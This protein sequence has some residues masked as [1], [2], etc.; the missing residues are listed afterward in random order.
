MKWLRTIA[1]T[2]IRDLDRHFD[3]TQHKRYSEEFYLFM[4]SSQKPLQAL[5]KLSQRFSW[6]S[7]QSSYGSNSLEYEKMDE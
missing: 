7:D 5:K 1:K 2:L 6:G 4:R 3:D